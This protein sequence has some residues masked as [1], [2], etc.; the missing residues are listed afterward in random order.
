MVYSA[1]EVE[2]YGLS[3]MAFLQRTLP[4]FLHANEAEHYEMK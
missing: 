4:C 1:L 2:L 3:L